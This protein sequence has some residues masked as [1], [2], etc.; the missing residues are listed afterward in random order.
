MNIISYRGPKSPGGVSATLARLFQTSANTARR[1]WFISGLSLSSQESELREQSNEL[2]LTKAIVDGHYRYCNEFLWPILHDLPVHSKYNSDDKCSYDIFNLATS[3]HIYDS[4]TKGGCRDC[5]VNDYQFAL[6]PELLSDRAM[7][8]TTFWHIPWP[9]HVRQ[10]HEEAIIE[11]ARGLLGSAKLGFHTEE[12]AKNF[13]TFVDD[14]L[15]QYSVDFERKLI[16]RG[17]RPG[18]PTSDRFRRKKTAVVVKPLGIDYAYWRD[19]AQAE[20]NLFEDS[21]LS[22]IPKLPY[23]LSVDRGDYTKGILQR[24]DA[25]DLFF[26][27][28]P[29][30]QGELVFLQVCQQ[31]RL[32]LSAFN[33][34]W[35]KCR[36]RANFINSKWG[37]EGW[38][39]VAW[40][41]EPLEAK[42][43]SKL[44]RMA[45]AML[46]TPLR[47]G[48]NLTAKEYIACAS[49]NPGALILSSAAGAWHELKPHALTINPQDPEDISNKIAIA[50]KMPHEER[51]SRWL[52]MRHSI[53]ANTLATWSDQFST[54][55]YKK[56]P[57]FPTHV[58]PLRIRQ[59]AAQ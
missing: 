4:I 12:Y 41:Q 18:C 57:I 44:Y 50:L 14:H 54:E 51:L 32:G 25:I 37:K 58:E 1:W 43:I 39:P 56:H 15:P 23:V 42:S 24:L 29:A 11:I 27:T 16:I 22:S 47:D 2:K 10:E 17:D 53:R 21:R 6:L 55:Q 33:D 35:K 46:I 19:L 7:N 31:S 34:Y 52:K 26:M 13:L 48:L 38:Q 28:N 45:S 9:K 20:D 36:E 5:F 3:D 59:K 40:V 49:D 30:Y 8:I